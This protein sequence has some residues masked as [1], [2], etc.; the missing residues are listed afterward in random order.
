[1]NIASIVS[2]IAREV[3]RTG[4]LDPNGPL[5]THTGTPAS[6]EVASADIGKEIAARV[7]A[8][9]VVQHVTNSEPWYRS[10]VTWG[11]I[12][13]IATPVLGMAGVALAPEDREAI[14]TAALL[15][16]PAVGGLVSLYGR[17]VSRKPIGA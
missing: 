9:P 17:W 15:L 13:S 10:R 1:M 11:A 6:V 3:T 8:D 16:G 14:I 5:T 12:I 7:A 2:T 4:I